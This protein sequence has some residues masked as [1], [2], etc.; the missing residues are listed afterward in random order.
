[1]ISPL[2]F[3]Q[4]IMGLHGG[5]MTI[6][7]PVRETTKWNQ[8]LLFLQYISTYITVIIRYSLKSIK[9]VL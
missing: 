5:V 9:S 7:I 4:S 8:L 3:S 2:G 6:G 1:M